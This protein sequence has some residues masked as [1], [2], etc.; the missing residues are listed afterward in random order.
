MKPFLNSSRATGLLLLMQLVAGP[1]VNFVLMGPVEAPPGFLANA[2]SHAHAVSLAVVLA[3]AMAVVSLGITVLVWPFLER[4]SPALALLYLAL[5][6]ANFGTEVAEQ[7][8][9]LSMLSLSQASAAASD[10]GLFRGPGIVVGNAHHWAHYLNL[11]VGGLSLT[12]FYAGL[13]RDAL[14]PRWLA[15]LGLLAT[16]MLL[17]AVVPPLFGE[18][19]RFVLLAPIGLAQ[20]VLALW[21]LV[22]GFHPP[23][24]EDRR[25]PA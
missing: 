1:I 12:V 8:A 17:A 11:I 2:A 14:V 20:L 6:I 24:P 3:L 15:G 22:R 25:R 23:V 7:T 5:G 16:L 4:G 13:L 19:I 21:L 10:P 18:E 9:A